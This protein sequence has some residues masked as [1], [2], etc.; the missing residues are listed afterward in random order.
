MVHT[1]FIYSPA[2]EPY[3]KNADQ[4]KYPRSVITESNNLTVESVNRKCA[5]NISFYLVLKQ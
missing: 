1:W 2:T 3:F 4:F 5:E